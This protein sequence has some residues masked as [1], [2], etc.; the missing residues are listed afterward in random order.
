MST[1]V[2]VGAGDGAGSGNPLA[3]LPDPVELRARVTTERAREHLLSLQRDAGWWKGNLQTNVTMDAEDLLLRT[4]L[5]ILDPVD[6]ELSARWIR[7][8]QREDGTWST[9]HDGPA[10]LSTTVE[11]Y[12]ALK[13]AGDDVDA[14]HM[15]AAREFVLA[16]GGI[17][18]TR[19][20]TRIWLA[21]FGE[22]SWDELPVM[23]PEMIFLPSWFPLNVYDWGCWA[24]QTVVPLTIVCALRPV[25]S[26]GIAL[27]ELHTT[28]KSVSKAPLLS[29]GGAF[30]QLDKALHVYQKLPV[31]PF[32][33]LALRQAAEWIVAR[34]EDDG[35]WGG[36]QPPWVYSIMALHLMGY[37]LDHPVLAKALQGLEGFTVREDT[38]AGPVRWLEACQ[39]PVWDTCLALIG[40]IDAGTPADDPA[41]LR[42]VDWLLGEEI[43]VPGDWSVRRPDVEPGG[44]A[45]EFGNDMYP[46]TDDTAEVVLALRLAGHPDDVRRKEAIRRGI[47]WLIGMQSRDGGWGAFDADN[48]QA[49][50]LKLP[51]CDFGAVIDPP[52]ADVTAHIVEMLAKEGLASHPA[53]RAG[54]RWLLRSQEDDG[55]W[56]GRWGANHVYGTGAAVPALV[57][58]GLSTSDGAIR[59]A[60]TWLE[61]CQNADGGWGEDL[62]SYADSAWRGRGVSTASQTAWALL[63]LLAAGETGESVRR[64]VEWLGETQRPDGSWDEPQFT[65]TG[66]PGDFYINYHL[67]RM[68]FPLSA[69]GRYLDAVRAADDD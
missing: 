63:A 6:L 35:S 36:I 55:S 11:A 2:E 49:L 8:Q 3:H 38:A 47:D 67:Y 48:T 1:A 28:R 18:A 46:D 41:V 56:F 34:Q 27:D 51:F 22:W 19:V 24:R 31:Q 25:R 60:V 26:L 42:A 57:A 52:S 10:D 17:A 62:R 23:P 7:S 13:L 14:P 21:L 5:G 15:A 69:L 65:G 66:F 59:R 9:F 53:T 50:T 54:V 68:V 43:R 4:F 61:S 33:K 45:F 64:G 16:G 44:W 37:S 12:V 30:E 58:A 40:L 29:I 39:S 32:R 20:F